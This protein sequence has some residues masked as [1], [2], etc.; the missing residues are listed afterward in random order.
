MLC[1][2]QTSIPLY[3]SH[4]FTE[5]EAASSIR[6]GIDICYSACV[7][8][9]SPVAKVCLSL[10]PYG[11]TQTPIS[12]EYTGRY[13]SPYGPFASTST[14][15]PSSDSSSP[16]YEQALTEFH[17]QRLEIFAS[18]SA[19]WSKIHLIA[20]ET[21]PLL[22]EALAIR[23]AMH[24]LY[25]LHP[26]L[27]KKAFYISY[28][29]PAGLLPQSLHFPQSN[30]YTPEDI[31]R[32]TFEQVEGMEVPYGIGVNCTKMKWIKEIVVGFEKGSPDRKEKMLV[33]Y[34]DGG[35]QTYDPTT[36]V[37]ISSAISGQY[38]MRLISLDLA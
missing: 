23:K 17:L 28:V 13:T 14:S 36:Q 20:F 33:V 12:A 29:F 3:I 8:S 35:G 5:T 27:E 4:G 2:Y 9:S 16:Q 26:G 34:P 7:E 18:E 6:S 32:V 15:E 10:G 22:T 30:D 38:V 37:S 25:N 31:S 11:A 19:L 21:I 1:R 24:Q